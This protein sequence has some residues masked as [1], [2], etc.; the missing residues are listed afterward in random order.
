MTDP[1]NRI[2]SGFGRRQ[3]LKTAEKPVSASRRLTGKKTFSD[4]GMPRSQHDR[5]I[6]AM[7]SAGNDSIDTAPKSI[8]ERLALLLKDDNL[9]TLHGRK[10][11]GHILAYYKFPL[12]ILCI[13]L[14]IIGYNVHRHLTHKDIV[15]YAALV[16]V[17]AGEDL[18]RQLGEDFLAHSGADPSKYELK[19]YAELYLTDDELNAYHEYTYASRM[20]IL[21]CIEGKQMDV[22]LMNQEA[23]DAF[24]QN[25]YLH[26][27]DSI[28]SEHA[29]DL[30]GY[31]RPDLVSNMVILEDNADDLVLDD[32]V[33]YTA[34]TREALYGLDLS[35]TPL[36]RQ[37]GFEDPVYLGIIANSPR[38]DAVM[39]Y[40]RYLTA[41]GES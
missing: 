35:D 19:L 7:K 4:T 26:D 8:Q 15:L 41:G 36:I 33:E 10:K 24:S 37:A 3:S 16:N 28:L 31:L 23:F 11:I 39:E 27:L 13:F 30:Y 1:Q 5:R 12:V 40:L 6:N 20:K 22:V 32:S 2:E 21:A 14:Y 29:P 18:T 34:V 25:G 38:L 9:N 17:V